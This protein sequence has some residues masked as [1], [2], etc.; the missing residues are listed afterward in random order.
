MAKQHRM[1]VLTLGAVL[2]AFLPGH[3]AVVWALWIIVIGALLTCAIR[4]ARIAR[5][6]RARSEQA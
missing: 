1:F 2:A 5:L 4:T 6:L 3:A